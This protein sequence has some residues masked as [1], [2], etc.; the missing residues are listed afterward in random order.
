MRDFYATSA[1]VPLDQAEGLRQLF[2]GRAGRA[3][4]VIALAANPHVAFNA[5]VLDRVAAMLSCLGR[6][7]LVVDAA[8]SA[9]APN[10]LARLDLAAGIEPMMPGVAYLP[11]R[12]LLMQYVDTRGSAARFVEALFDAVPSADVVLVHAEAA[13]LARMLVRTVARPLL[14][15]ADHPESLKH[16]YASCKLLMQR[17]G[18]ATFDLLLAASARS[19]RILSIVASLRGCAD[20]FLGALVHDWALIDPALPVPLTRDEMR[21]EMSDGVADDAHAGAQGDPH[22]FARAARLAALLAA[23]LAL[24]DAPDSAPAPAGA[25]LYS[26]PAAPGRSLPNDR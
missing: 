11:A 14:M 26:E 5:T 6:Q 9:P 22:D 15:A 8:L 24:D 20:S 4:Q 25:A 13:D 3:R 12:G 18:L 1:S 19:P 2:A 17:T 10:E 7:V 16:A 23:Q 21:A